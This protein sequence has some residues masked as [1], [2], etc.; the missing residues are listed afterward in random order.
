MY[1]ENTIVYVPHVSLWLAVHVAYRNISIVVS[2]VSSRNVTP[3][4]IARMHQLP[5]ALPHAFSNAS[6]DLSWYILHI[7]ILL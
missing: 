4:L 5:A 6:T 2:A 1:G 7:D 3:S